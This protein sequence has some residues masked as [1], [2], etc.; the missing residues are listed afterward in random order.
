MHPL[1]C[2]GWDGEEIHGVFS[3]CAVTFQLGRMVN[4]QPVWEERRLRGFKC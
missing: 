1:T 2:Y 3:Y 4:G